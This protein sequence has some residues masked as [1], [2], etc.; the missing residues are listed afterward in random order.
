MV[1]IAGNVF[2]DFADGGRGHNLTLILH[3][4]SEALKNRYCFHTFKR[5]EIG[6]DYI[7]KDRRKEPFFSGSLHGL[8]ISRGLLTCTK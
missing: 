7:V 5:L 1:K 4:A 6:E 2:M 3:G 8:S